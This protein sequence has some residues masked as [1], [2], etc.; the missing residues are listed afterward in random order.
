MDENIIVQ[1]SLARREL[2]RQFQGY[3]ELFYVD[4]DL[5]Y[6]PSQCKQLHFDTDEG[7]R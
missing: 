7:E 3:A 4:G 6:R 2:S 1:T 5:S